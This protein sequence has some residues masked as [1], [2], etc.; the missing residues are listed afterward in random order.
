M[1]QQNK[2][3]GGRRPGAG[4]PPKSLTERQLFA[5]K[6]AIRISP[7]VAIKLQELMLRQI[8]GVSTPEQM[9]EYL[10]RN[11]SCGSGR[12]KGHEDVDTSDT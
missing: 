4:R 5:G 12:A 7:E 3:R 2:Q 8:D 10:I 11:A 1:G 9:V 6:V